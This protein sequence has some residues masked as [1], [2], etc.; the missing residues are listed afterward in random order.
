[1]M[2]EAESMPP[3]DVAVRTGR[4]PAD[5][6]EAL[7][8]LIWG[9]TEAVMLHINGTAIPLHMERS[10]SVQWKSRGL[11]DSGVF[12]CPPETGWLRSLLGCIGM[13]VVEK[14]NSLDSILV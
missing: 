1:M 8:E 6:D 2:E 4:E 11:E 7:S 3:E 14:S 13:S 9:D 10:S 12:A 5:E